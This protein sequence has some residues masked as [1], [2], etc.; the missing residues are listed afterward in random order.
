MIV[1]SI[2]LDPKGWSLKLMMFT[3]LWT[4]LAGAAFAQGVPPPCQTIANDIADLKAERDAVQG[5]TKEA[6]AE[7]KALDK[8]IAAKKAELEKCLQQNPPIAGEPFSMQGGVVLTPAQIANTMT[9]CAPS[10]P[11]LGSVQ[12]P[13]SFTLSPPPAASWLASSCVKGNPSDAQVAASSTH[14]IVTFE[15]SMAWYGKSGVKQG[16]LTNFDLFHPLLTTLAPAVGMAGYCVNKGTSCVQ[17]QSDFRVI[18]DE[19]RKRFWALDGAGIYLANNP[20]G[21]ARGI[22]MVAVSKSEDPKDGWY[23]YWVDAVAH[24]GKANDKVYK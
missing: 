7:R 1:R 8:Q 10:K 5:D 14:V 22:F 13:P 9:T 4:P 24:W 11:P 12:P 21:T 20:P 15:S 2:A 18:F 23:L 19:Y 6:V 16:E 17:T 3:L